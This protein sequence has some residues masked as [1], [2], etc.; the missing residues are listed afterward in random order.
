MDVGDNPVLFPN[1]PDMATADDFHHIFSDI[2]EIDLGVP[3]SEV[4]DNILE[5]DDFI[6][7]FDFPDVLHPEYLHE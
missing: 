7:N 6:S 2:S 4:Q 3:T 5:I 1:D